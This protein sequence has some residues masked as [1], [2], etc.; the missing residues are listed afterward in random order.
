MAL[1]ISSR[2]P[3]SCGEQLQATAFR[4]QPGTGAGKFEQRLQELRASH[5]AEDDAGSAA[6]EI[7]QGREEI[8]RSRGSAVRL[9]ARG[10]P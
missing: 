3:N 2:S 9:A 8:P 10:A 1:A 4:P 5:G 6:I 7:R